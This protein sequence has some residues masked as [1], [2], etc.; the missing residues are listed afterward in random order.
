MSP[1]K[2]ILHNTVCSKLSHVGSFI[3]HDSLLDSFRRNWLMLLNEHFSQLIMINNHVSSIFGSV[4]GWRAKCKVTC[5]WKAEPNR[6]RVHVFVYIPADSEDSRHRGERENWGSGGLL[7]IAQ[8]ACVDEINIG[9]PWGLPDW[10]TQARW[11]HVWFIFWIREGDREREREDES[12]PHWWLSTLSG[13][14]IQ[15]QKETEATA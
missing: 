2:W 7:V 12:L 4:A 15:V 13:Q 3:Q 6:N 8:H 10:I 14:I 5:R 9:C 1:A 11:R